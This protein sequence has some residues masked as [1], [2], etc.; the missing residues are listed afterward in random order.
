MFA[1]GSKF[2]LRVGGEK[3]AYYIY[4]NMQVKLP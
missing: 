3:A 4:L 1:I 2:L